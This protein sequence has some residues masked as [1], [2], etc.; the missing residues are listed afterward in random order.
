MQRI[1]EFGIHEFHRYQDMHEVGYQEMA[2]RVK[3]LQELLKY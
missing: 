3:E 1:G 2:S